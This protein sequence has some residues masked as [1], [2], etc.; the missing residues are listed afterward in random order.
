MSEAND[1]L[2][3]WQ[4]WSALPGGK[5]LFSFGVGRMAPYTSSISPRVQELRAGYARVRMRDRRRLRNHLRSVHAIAMMNLA[6][7]T[8]GLAMLAGMPDDARAIIT[9][10][11][12]EYKKK[13]R[14]A[15][16]AE[17]TTSPPASNERREY[18]LEAV[19]RDVAGDEVARATARW[20]VGPR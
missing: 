19:V 20:L 2:R 3:R 4:R 10:L 7:V 9:N 6:E 12:I 1:M 17:C 15:L 18:H 14:G 13:A 8:S 16:E 5:T 11:A